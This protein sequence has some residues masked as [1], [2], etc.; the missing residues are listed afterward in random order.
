[1]SFLE[2]KISETTQKL[3]NCQ[4]LLALE[5]KRICTKHNIRFF[6]IAGTLLGAVRHHGFIPWDDDM[7]FAVMRSDYEDFLSACKEDLGEDFILQEMNTD[8][9]YGLP[10][11][12]IL[13]KGTRLTERTTK[14]NKTLKG[15]YIDVFPYDNIPDRQEPRKK[16]EK[17]LYVLKRLFLAKQGYKIAQ[18]G[19]FSKQFIYTVLK[20]ASFF[21]SKNF[22]RNSL[23]KEMKRF[24]NE[25]TELVAA[26]GGAYSYSKESV[27]RSWFEETVMLPFENT[28]LPAPK[29]YE[30]YLTCFYGDYMTP[31]PE[32]KR[33]NRHNVVELDFG[34]F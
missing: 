11:A 25:K 6:M 31:P 3:H 26:I 15:I 33:D 30:E 1:M 12:K 13:L 34:K 8:P 18:K 7:D 32:D 24:E 19:E 29:D 2:Y 28:E 10:M 20:I 21:M 27:K 4:L 5:L 14:D 17:R 23:D 22:I 16:H 9:N